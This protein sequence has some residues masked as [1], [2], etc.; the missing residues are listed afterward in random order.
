MTLVEILLGLTISTMIIVPLGAWSF[1]V[2]KAQP[3]TAERMMKTIHSGFVAMYAPDDVASAIA[4][5]NLAGLSAPAGQQWWNDWSR[6]DCSGGA[7]AGGRKLMVLLSNQDAAVGAGGGSGGAG[8][9]SLLSAGDQV[10][11]VY[12]IAASSEEPGQFSIWRRTCKAVDHSPTIDSREIYRRIDPSLSRSKVECRSNSGQLPCQEVKLSLTPKGAR[13]PVVVDV[14]RRTNAEARLLVDD[15]SQ[16][17]NHVPAARISVT[18]ITPTGQ[19]QRAVVVLD[20]SASRDEDGSIVKY[21]WRIPSGPMD[22]GAPETE[23]AGADLKQQSI[24]LPRAGDY[25]IELTVTDDKGATNTAYKRV[26]VENRKPVA[27]GSVSATEVSLGVTPFDLDGSAS[28]DADGS[29][30]TASS[31]WILSGITP[32]GEAGEIQLSGLRH[33]GLVLG[34]EWKPGVVNLSL[35]VVDNDGASDV[36]TTTMNLREAP[37]AGQ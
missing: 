32:A 17:G 28:T 22:S 3:M 7:G 14:L 5:D 36:F 12:S 11:T 13:S 34:A 16:S 23:A 37:A 20:G 35:V 27:V 26:V 2:L 10:K 4:A 21:S 19:G 15:G 6:S 29:I 31:H 33:N 30:D 25:S 1:T 24:T 9:G 18:S 8:G